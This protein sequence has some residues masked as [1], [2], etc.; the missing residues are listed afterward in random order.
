MQPPKNPKKP[1]KVPKKPEYCPKCKEGPLNPLRDYYEWVSSMCKQCFKDYQSNRMR[2]SRSG[3]SSKAKPRKHPV[4]FLPPGMTKAQYV[5]ALFKDPAN[6][7]GQMQKALVNPES[8]TAV[9][10]GNGR[11]QYLAKLPG[12]VSIPEPDDLKVSRGNYALM[13][14]DMVQHGTNGGKKIIEFWLRVL[15]DENVPLKY[16]FAV[17]QELANR[18]FGKAP[19]EIKADI[20]VTHRE[21]RQ[22]I[23][24][25]SDSEL[26]ELDSPA[27]LEKYITVEVVSKA[28]ADR[29]D[30]DAVPGE[31]IRNEL[32]EELSK[33]LG[34]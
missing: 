26:A 33:E 12:Y 27:D 17:S 24:G 19:Q 25:L 31:E 3:V 7:P 14:A 10:V 9:D 30:E 16:R 20:S 4:E 23:G 8:C 2:Q 1:K 34:L 18:L 6:I 22:R 5:K 11:G 32:Q 13:I 28:I 21:I 29:G 15:Y